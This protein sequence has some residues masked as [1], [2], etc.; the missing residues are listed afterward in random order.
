MQMSV[1]VVL[2]TL[3]VAGCRYTVV[4]AHVGEQLCIGCGVHIHCSSRAHCG[5]MLYYM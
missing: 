3:Y 1:H 5:V 4:F 2:Y